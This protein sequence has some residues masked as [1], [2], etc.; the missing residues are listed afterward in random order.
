MIAEGKNAVLTEDR[1]EEYG[2]AV[3]TLHIAHRVFGDPRYL[4][5]RDAVLNT[6]RQLP[7]HPKNRPYYDAMTAQRWWRIDDQSNYPGEVQLMCGFVS[8]YGQT[9]AFLGNH[10]EL[11]KAQDWIRWAAMRESGFT[12]SPFPADLAPAFS[13]RCGMIGALHGRAAY[14]A[15]PLGDAGPPAPEL[16]SRAGEV[17]VRIHPAPRTDPMTE[18]KRKAQLNSRY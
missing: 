10:D 7:A 15:T 6:M 4:R 9:C 17:V 8:I 18:G 13:Q 14:L 2:Y 5:A 12:D 3:A 11:E 16:E 1:I